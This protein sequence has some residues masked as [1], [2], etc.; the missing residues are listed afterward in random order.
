[1]IPVSVEGQQRA[2][3]QRLAGLA[4]EKGAKG[5]KKDRREREDREDG[6]TGADHMAEG[7]M[8]SMAED[9]DCDGDGTLKSYED[10]GITEGP[11]RYVTPGQITAQQFQREPLGEGQAA[12]SPQ[13]EPPNAMPAQAPTAPVP[14]HVDLS[15]S[16]ALVAQVHPSAP[17]G[18]GGQR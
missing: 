2:E 16:Q 11:G 15:G 12:V 7:A 13:H 4:A 8:N 6:R 18:P 1:M 3:Q 14:R 5:G 10:V 9:E 17:S